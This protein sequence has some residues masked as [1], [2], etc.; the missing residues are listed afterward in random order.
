MKLYKYVSRRRKIRIYRYIML[1]VLA[2]I[3]FFYPVP[4]GAGYE[5]I[6]G[7]SSSNIPLTMA[8]LLLLGKMLATSLTLNSGG[9]G[10]LCIPTLFAWAILGNI[11][12]TLTHTPLEL[13]V[14]MAMASMLAATNKT[15]LTSL[16]FV[17][18]STATGNLMYVGLAS[19]VSYFASG[20][21]SF[22]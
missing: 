14:P 9:C 17:A 3:L 4:G 16:L 20:L 18:E 11:Y 22:E 2:A 7:S 15:L 12:S 13:A 1:A 5:V 8:L 19:A 10:G 21:E 6:A